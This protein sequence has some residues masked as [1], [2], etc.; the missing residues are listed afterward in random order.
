[1]IKTRLQLQG[2]LKA[3]GHYVEPYKNFLQGFIQIAKHDGVKAL[4][5]GLTASLYF[6]F[7]LNA[8][9]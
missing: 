1:M 8:A 4:Q 3:K 6:Q 7:L 9:R 2:E 5:L